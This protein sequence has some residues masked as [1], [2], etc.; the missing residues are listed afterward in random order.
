MGSGE[1]VSG[2]RK[3]S[4]ERGSVLKTIG[5]NVP[6]PDVAQAHPQVSE[7]GISG[8]EATLDLS[9]TIEN[10]DKVILY[11]ILRDQSIIKMAEVTV[12]LASNSSKVEVPLREQDAGSEMESLQLKLQRIQAD[13]ERS[14]VFVQTVKTN[15]QNR[16]Q[17]TR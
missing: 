1:G 11:G 4:N 9:K 17:I 8:F 7:A 15:L 10:T 13:L 5:V 6:R 12:K 2:D 3:R 16:E 14:K